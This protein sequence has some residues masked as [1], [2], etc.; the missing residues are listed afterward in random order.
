M[1][2]VKVVSW[3]RASGGYFHVTLKKG[4]ISDLYKAWIISNMNKWIMY[5]QNKINTM[6]IYSKRKSLAD[7]ISGL[8]YCWEFFNF[9]CLSSNKCSWTQLVKFRTGKWEISV[10]FSG[11]LTSW[12]QCGSLEKTTQGYLRRYHLNIPNRMCGDPWGDLLEA[13]QPNQ[14]QRPLTFVLHKH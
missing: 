5:L 8:D 1:K 4:I 11:G 9:S 3:W 10:S 14:T 12:I 13:E 6:K 7:K 2:T